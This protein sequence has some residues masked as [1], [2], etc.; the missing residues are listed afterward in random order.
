MGLQLT[1]ATRAGFLV[2]LTAV[3]VPVLSALAGVKV[4]S[5]I[6]GAAVLALSGTC[7]IALDGAA[8]ASDALSAATDSPI[9][10]G[11]LY[12]LGACLFYSLATVRLGTCF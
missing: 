4:S 7:L 9:A 5:R 6:W 2:Q 1:S 8:P 11:D 10:V 3:L 12:L